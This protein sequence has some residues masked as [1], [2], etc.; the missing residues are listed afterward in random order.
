MV[1]AA[2]AALFRAPYTVR[3]SIKPIKYTC[4]LVPVEKKYIYYE[5]NIII[6]FKTKNITGDY[7][8]IIAIITPDVQE[9]FK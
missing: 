1:F 4:G 3:T 9:K 8:A 7:S 2:C 6:D 5:K